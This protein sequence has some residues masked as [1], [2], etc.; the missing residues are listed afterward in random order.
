MAKV[1]DF[2]PYAAPETDG[3]TAV[4]QFPLRIWLY[5][6]A[7][8]LML[9]LCTAKHWFAVSSEE[10]GFAFLTLI[11]GAGFAYVTPLLWL[12]FFSEWLGLGWFVSKD[13][14]EAERC[15]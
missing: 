12:L 13:R 1:S 7:G 2:N 14:A 3:M 10:W 8:S 15:E 9:V 4:R 5:S 6:V 11:L